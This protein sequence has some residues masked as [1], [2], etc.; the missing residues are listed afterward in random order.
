MSPGH[1]LID[2]TVALVGVS[3]WSFK[4]EWV[5][6]QKELDAQGEAP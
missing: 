1:G 5:D 3:A 4:R 6:R 2:S